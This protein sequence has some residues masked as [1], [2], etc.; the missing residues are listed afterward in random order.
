MAA[1][2]ALTAIVINSFVLS[3]KFETSFPL[4]A[5]ECCILSLFAPMYH[6]YTNMLCD[7]KGVRPIDWLMFIPPIIVVTAFAILMF[8]APADS[9]PAMANEIYHNTNAMS[10][11][12][13]YLRLTHIV[14]RFYLLVPIQVLI[15]MLFSIINHRNYRKL[16][17][18][19]CS[20]LNK[21]STAPT[22][23]VLMILELFL[24]GTLSLVPTMAQMQ[25]SVLYILSVVLAICFHFK[26]KMIFNAR[27]T[28]EEIQWQ[29]Q[30]ASSSQEERQTITKEL[31]DIASDTNKP[32]HIISDETFSRIK[33]EKLYTDPHLSLISLAAK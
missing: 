7:I 16:I 20:D 1:I 29:I 31:L 4:I 15:V 3:P 19:Y 30:H 33:K 18:V 25:E 11:D 10:Y 2:V 24:L 5:I 14:F 9:Y 27:M 28:A 22:P 6:I 26:G 21:E 17:Y 13:P 8:A 23:A 32:G 12:M